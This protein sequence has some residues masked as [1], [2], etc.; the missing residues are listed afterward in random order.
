MSVKTTN[1]KHQSKTP[2][3]VFSQQLSLALTG[4]YKTERSE[5]IK[6]G[7]AKRKAMHHDG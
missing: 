7:L 3:Q 1:Q 4:Y 5:R 6:R 2:N